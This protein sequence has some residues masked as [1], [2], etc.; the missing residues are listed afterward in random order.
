MFN[1]LWVTRCRE[2]LKKLSTSAQANLKRV[3]GGKPELP[4]EGAAGLGLHPAA[5]SDRERGKVADETRQNR[6]VGEALGAG[7]RNHADAAVQFARILHGRGLDQEALKILENVHGLQCV[8]RPW[9]LEPLK[10]G[11]QRT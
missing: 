4:K 2:V 6:Q 9:S 5:P 10:P 1:D 3:R 8:E 7:S 11:S